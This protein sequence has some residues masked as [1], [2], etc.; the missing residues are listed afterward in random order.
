MALNKICFD[1][2]LLGETGMLEMHGLFDTPPI[3]KVLCLYFHDFLCILLA[4]TISF[5]S[6]SVPFLRAQ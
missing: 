4:C 1:A 6:S 2:P 3:R 5:R